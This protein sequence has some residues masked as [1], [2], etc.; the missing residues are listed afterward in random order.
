[1]HDENIKCILLSCE[2]RCIDGDN[3]HYLRELLNIH[4]E[5]PD[6]A[7]RLTILLQYALE[8][9][10]YESINLLL[11]R[12]A[13]PYAHFLDAK[14]PPAINPDLI[15]QIQTVAGSAPIGLIASKLLTDLT[16]LYNLK[17]F[18]PD[19][20]KKLADVT[21]AVAQ[22]AE[23]HNA[24]LR[25]QQQQNTQREQ[26]QSAIQHADIA[27]V[28]QILKSDTPVSSQNVATALSYT[29]DFI[30]KWNAIIDLLTQY[31]A[32]HTA[33]NSRFS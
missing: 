28:H 27:Q 12:G 8:K 23:Q 14:A 2:H 33:S 26:L 5:A 3:A 19:I 13:K 30:V 16:P 22:A 20:F 11:S 21:A 6:F 25:W 10:K 7:H 29:R 31:Q 18:Q 15:Y 4:P 1:M 32:Q 17:H 24:Q 9:E